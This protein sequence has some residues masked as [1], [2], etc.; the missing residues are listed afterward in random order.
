MTR[1]RCARPSASGWRGPAWAC[2]SAPPPLPEAVRGLF[3]FVLRTTGATDGVLL[4]H[5]YDA[6]RRPAEECRVYGL[7]GQPLQVELAPFARSLAAGVVGLGQPHAL[8][9]PGEAAGV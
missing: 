9:H 7:D 8:L 2:A 5:T 1:R 6:E 3:R 4:V